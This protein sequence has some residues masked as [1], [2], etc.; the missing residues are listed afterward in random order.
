VLSHGEAVDLDTE[1][2]WRVLEKLIAGGA[3]GS[4]FHES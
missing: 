4:R 1:D 3:G 2:D